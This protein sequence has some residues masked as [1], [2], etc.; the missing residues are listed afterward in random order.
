MIRKFLLSVPLLVAAGMANAVDAPPS[1]KSV[2]SSI[3]VSVGSNQ[4]LILF[5]RGIAMGM[6]IVAKCLWNR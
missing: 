5:M 6:S 2:L 1:M 3:I 4:K